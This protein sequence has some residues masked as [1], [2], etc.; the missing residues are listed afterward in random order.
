ME[1]EGTVFGGKYLLNTK[2]GQGGMGSV[3]RAEHVQLK[4]PVAVKLIDPSIAN[5]AEALARFM[6]EAQSAAAL[7]SPHV[8]QILDHG[9]DHGVPYIAMELLDGESLA[10]RL[11]R[12]RTLSPPETASILTQ[13]ARAI[14]KAHE[15]GIVHRDLKPDNVFIVKNDDEEVAKVLDFGIAKNSGVAL[16]PSSST[17]SGA[18]LG[19]PYYMSPEQAEGTRM[20][21][22]RTDIWAFGVIA[23][24]CMLGR[25]PFESEAFGGL[26]L[27]ICTRPLPIPSAFG[28]VPAGFDEWFARTCAREPDRRF[29]SAR[30]A[31][32]DLKRLCTGAAARISVSGEGAHPQSRFSPTPH[33]YTPSSHGPT[34]PAASA[35]HPRTPGFTANP[36]TASVEPTLKRSRAPLLVGLFVGAA[37]VALAVIG[38]TKLVQDRNEAAAALAAP[39]VADV[40]AAPPAPTPIVEPAPP[41]PVVVPSAPVERPSPGRARPRPRRS[42]SLHP[43]SARARVRPGPRARRPRRLLPPPPHP[44]P[45]PPPGGRP[46]PRSPR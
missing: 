28:P 1:W 10:T 43:S 3:W 30:E 13:V 27:A 46:P 9:A 16:G 38:A 39:P 4:S 33:P 41:P 37:V 35:P 19:T 20:V 18:L 11:D 8:V 31:A 25:R 5:N 21:D 29:G 7:R 17:R 6:R 26:L 40:P 12:V 36:F 23:F 45:P 14:S 22:F 15:A 42:P 2:L 34:V 32:S 24:E 44:P